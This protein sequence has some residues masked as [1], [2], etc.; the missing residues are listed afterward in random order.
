MCSQFVSNVQGNQER[1]TNIILN[2]ELL[3]LKYVS[4][5]TVTEL[6]SSPPPLFLAAPASNLKSSSTNLNNFR[7]YYLILFPLEKF[8]NKNFRSLKHLKIIDINFDHQ[9]IFSIC[10]FI[11]SQAIVKVMISKLFFISGS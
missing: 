10:P 7:I 1:A 2:N 9:L 8:K 11:A 3:L 4:S 5:N 6:R